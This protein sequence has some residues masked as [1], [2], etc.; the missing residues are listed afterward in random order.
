MDDLLLA[1]DLLPDAELLRLHREVCRRAARIYGPMYQATRDRNY[2]TAM[3]IRDT[4]FQKG[5]SPL[6]NVRRCL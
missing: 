2:R 1:I 3:S 4:R 6:E 5:L